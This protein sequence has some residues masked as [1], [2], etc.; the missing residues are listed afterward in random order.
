MHWKEQGL[1]NLNSFGIINFLKRANLGD[2]MLA[3]TIQKS[4]LAELELDLASS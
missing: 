2:G 1:L 3:F 4:T